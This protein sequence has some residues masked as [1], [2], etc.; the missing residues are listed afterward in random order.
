MRLGS[1][2]GCAL[3]VWIAFS[4][5]LNP[6]QNIP[7]IATNPSTALDA[8][9]NTSAIQIA[10][11]P[12]ENFPP[13]ISN[14]TSSLSLANTTSLTGNATLTDTRLSCNGAPFTRPGPASF[15]SCQNA[16]RNLHG[17]GDVLT[18]GDR[19][20]GDWD[21]ALPV[22]VMGGKLEPTILR[23]IETKHLS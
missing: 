8:P 11:I 5:V 21:V 9:S 14:P 4:L 3:H 16:L 6:P 19:A 23:L 13:S 1:L 10:S 17:G 2:L 12:S 18:F 20:A 7:G 22:R 15:A